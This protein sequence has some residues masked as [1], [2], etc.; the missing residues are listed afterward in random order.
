MTEGRVA[1][2]ERRVAEL[3][4]NVDTGDTSG[5]TRRKYLAGMGAVGGL[6]AGAGTA[7]ADTSDQQEQA[8]VAP[9][10]ASGPYT[11][12]L[13]GSHNQQQP[14]GG[15]K[16]AIESALAETPPKSIINIE[17]AWAFN[18]PIRFSSAHDT[19]GDGLRRM[20]VVLNAE[21]AT[22]EFGGRGFALVNDNTNRIPGQIAGGRL[23]INGGV[24]E[25]TNG[26]SFL[27]A[28]DA[29]HGH[30]DPRLTRNF[31]TV[32]SLEIGKKWC[33][34]NYISGDHL[35]GRVGVRACKRN[36]RAANGH[37]YQDNHIE[38]IGFAGFREYGFALSGNWIDCVF[39]NV[40][41][42]AGANDAAMCLYNG[43]L[44]GST[45]YNPEIE[46]APKNGNPLDR[47]YIVE[48]GPSNTNNGP[49]IT[50]MR[51]QNVIDKHGLQRIRA[52]AAGQVWNVWME[53]EDTNARHRYLFRGS[54]PRNGNAD[55]YGFKYH[56]RLTFSNRGLVRSVG[57]G[58][59]ERA[60]WRPQGWI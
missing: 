44:G 30:F 4:A 45:F 38:D 9:A 17:G 23:V 35:S 34:S 15:L 31:D 1:E 56:Q 3:E 47:Y 54:K 32:Y 14:R 7:S 53:E 60:N 55:R 16:P 10:D 52:D 50:G 11:T 41:F 12:T 20:P 2:L 58:R 27:R 13:V 37:S 8:A 42:I 28:I 21:G 19:H 33:E 5:T 43:N 49:L 29:I 59:P 36:G 22:I 26:G 51:N 6:L 39:D 57:R 40:T 48:V 18:S 24:W 25:A 46:S